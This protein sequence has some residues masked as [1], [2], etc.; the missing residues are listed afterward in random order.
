MGRVLVVLRCMCNTAQQTQQPTLEVDVPASPAPPASHAEWAALVVEG[1][2]GNAGAFQLRLSRLIARLRRESSPLANVLSRA[3]A[4]AHDSRLTLA[5]EAASQ[6]ATLSPVDSES[7]LS[8]TTVQYPVHLDTPPVWTEQVDTSLKQLI[9]EWRG[10]HKLLA[11]GLTPSRTLLLSGPPGVG[12]TL[13]AH[14]LAEQLQLPL[15]TLNLAAAVN[16]LLGKTGNNLVRVL[17]HARAQ[18]CVLLLDEFD[19]FAKRRDDGQ[20]VGELKRVVNVL[21]QAIDEW[22]A[23]SLLVAATNHEE[24]LDRAIFRRFD[25]WLRFPESSPAQVE[26]VLIGC[27]CSP[28]LSAIVAPTLAGRPLSDA[29][30]LVR[31]AQRQVALHGQGFEDALLAQLAQ[32][33]P[34]GEDVPRLLRAKQLKAAGWSLRAI[35]KDLKVNASTVSRLLHRTE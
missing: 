3:L 14:Y 18:P 29:T 31:R 5:R 21:L 24:L 12:K 13:A 33:L 28:A 1:C 20:D 22:P 10:A 6:Q 34:A 17:A 9:E 7:N 35:G 8:L 11:A 30:R 16:S 25:R 19:A 26:V 2:A 27:G 15:V 4:D 32:E 23:T